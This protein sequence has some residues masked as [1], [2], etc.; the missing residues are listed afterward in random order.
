MANITHQ[1]QQQRWDKEHQH[2]KVLPQMDSA[3]GSSGVVKFLDWLKAQ[4][5]KPQELSGME[6][7]CGKGRNVIWFAGQGAQMIGIDFS[8]AAISEAQ[9]RA[10]EAGMEDKTRFIVQDAT[11]PYPI[12]PSSLDFAF[13]CFGSTDIESAEGRKA[14]LNN[15]VKVLKPSGYL[16]VYLLSSDDEFQKEMITK[17]P[18]PDQGSFIHTVNGKY[19]KAFTEDEVKDF[20][21]DLKLCVLERVAKTD[22]F[23]GKEYKANHIW[24]VFQKQ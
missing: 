1:E 11:L 8:A 24:A 6:M 15:V 5:K 12:E 22:V 3:K 23:F 19:E 7:C 21:K 9:K 18:G 16:M 2:P 14:A 17:S 4:G 13:D 20:Y 10:K